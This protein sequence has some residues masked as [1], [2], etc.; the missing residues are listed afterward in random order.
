MK[1]RAL[2]AVALAGLLVLAS[3]GPDEPAPPASP[4]PARSAAPGD[5]AP[6]ATAPSAT[7][8]LTVRVMTREA[9]APVAG[10]QVTVA[11]GGCEEP[12]PSA[13]ADTD[14]EGRARVVL[15][16]DVTGPFDVTVR[17]AGRTRDHQMLDEAPNDEIVA[18]LDPAG[19][20]RGVV[21]GA[22]GKPVAGAVVHVDFD[23]H[24]DDLDDAKT[25]ATGGYEVD[26]VALHATF[27]L[28]AHGDSDQ[29]DA[30]M[31]LRR[32]L[33]VDSAERPLVADLTLALPAHLTV[34]VQWSDGLPV[35]GALV[36]RDPGDPSEWR[37]DQ[38]GAVVYPPLLAG[39]ERITVRCW[40]FE[41]ARN[42][43]DLK[44][45]ESRILIV[46]PPAGPAIEGTVVDDAGRWV[47]DATVSVKDTDAPTVTVRGGGK[48]RIACPD[49]SPRTITVTA[50][51]CVAAEVADVTPPESDLRVVLQRLPWV[52]CRLLLP[53][54]VSAVKRVTAWADGRIAGSN[55]DGEVLRIDVPQGTGDVAFRV[56]GCATVERKIDPAAGPLHDL[57]DVQLVAAPPLTGR[58]VDADGRPVHGFIYPK[59]G[60]VTVPL[61]STG[62]DGGF[63]IDGL[64]AGDAEV[65]VEADGFVNR[66]VHH[67]LAAG[68]PP[69]TI[70]LARGGGVR[71]L[72]LGA[73]GKPAPGA[74]YVSFVDVKDPQN[75]ERMATPSI[76]DDGRFEVHLA[77]GRY[78]AQTTLDDAEATA[79]VEVADGKT[80]EITLKLVT[81]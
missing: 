16:A 68:G 81:R 54:G 69:L 50:P 79:E 45:G 56:T 60:D 57:G 7:L 18:R 41:D 61:S 47:A 34:C 30:R 27:E 13:S 73:D 25:D 66:T 71:G 28:V 48:F 39:H 64:P 80:I 15:P 44:A 22:D 78:R 49:E 14:A 20:V 10:A 36:S 9:D 19:R 75:R 46:R 59:V 32:G 37:T 33:T 65:R 4:A 72:V 67:Q 55:F 62:D 11:T 5:D 24:D 26:G 52:R 63:S 70:T 1:Q 53:D 42:E 58:L 21:R 40:G 43:L 38:G 74:V 6:P 35:E 12:G 3:C 76:E 77:P 2:V 8:T 29:G 17:A 51:R 31:A 23:E